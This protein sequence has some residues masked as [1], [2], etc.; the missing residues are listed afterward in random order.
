MI[1]FDRIVFPTDFSECSNH[2]LGYAVLLA[3]R[4][5]SELHMLHAV[6]LHGDDPAN[7]EQRFPEAHALLDRLEKVAQSELGRVAARE[8]LAVLKVRQEQRR[9]FD[10]GSVILDFA[11]EIDAGLIVMGTHG[12]RGAR[13]LLLGSVAENVLR[14]SPV[15]VLFVRQ[16]GERTHLERID[17]IL[18]PVD[19]SPASKLAVR[20]A[21]ALA[22]TLAASLRLLH[23]IETPVLP[24]V[25]GQPMPFDTT[26]LR[27]RSLAALEQLAEEAGVADE[28]TDFLAS[29]GYP[30]T[31]I[32]AEAERLEA[33]LIV[34]PPFSRGRLEHFLTGRTTDLVVRTAPCPVL[35]TG[36]RPPVPGAEAE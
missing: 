17:T 29:P 24:S 7:P 36:V 26:D 12:R 32:V 4:F 8:D 23:V 31:E 19:F 11:R 2:A 10:P 14:R 16:S 5:E 22:E 34:M 20:Q 6:V 9:G 13:R 27:R 3:D 25:Y 21:A 30:A 1:H 33:G 35:T 15:P 28:G 18:A